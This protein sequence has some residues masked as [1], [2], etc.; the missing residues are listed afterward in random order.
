MRRRPFS[1]I[2]F[3][4]C[5]AFAAPGL[6]IATQ[7]EPGQ[8]TVFLIATAGALVGAGVYHLARPIWE[9]G[10]KDDLDNA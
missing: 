3:L 9:R 7:Y 2:K 6:M 8:F 4:F 1:V 5:M 10:A